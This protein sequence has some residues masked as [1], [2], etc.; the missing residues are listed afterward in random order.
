M[1]YIMKRYE[2]GF[3]LGINNADDTTVYD[4]KLAQLKKDFPNYPE[5]VTNILNRLKNGNSFSG[6]TANCLNY[7]YDIIL[8]D[9]GITHLGGCIPRNSNGTAVSD[10]YGS[11]IENGIV[12]STNY[13]IVCNNLKNKS[14]TETRFLGHTRGYNYLTKYEGTK[15]MTLIPSVHPIY[16]K[17]EGIY[18]FPFAN[19]YY[20]GSLRDNVIKTSEKFYIKNETFVVGFNHRLNITNSSTTEYLDSM[21]LYK[22]IL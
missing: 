9:N 4:E 2:A 16:G 22:I 1:S 8:S 12:Y 13:C 11:N 17:F 15:L 7:I 19:R 3:F 5:F 20:A 18:D 21:F 10:S 6:N 14:Y